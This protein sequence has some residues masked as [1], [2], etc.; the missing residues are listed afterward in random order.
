HAAPAIRAELAGE[1]LALAYPDRIARRRGGAHGQYQLA[2]GRSARLAE[3]DPLALEEWLVA[4]ELG[5]RSGEGSERIYLAAALSPLAFTGA[6]A[7]LVHTEEIAEWSEAEGRFIAER[8]RRV[9]SIV[10]S[11]ERISGV[12][13]GTRSE[14]LCRWIAATG[15]QVLPWTEELRQWQA[16]V[17]LLRSLGEL[18]GAPPWPAVDDTA[19]LATLGEWLAPALIEVGT[20]AA[21]Q[22][23]ALAAALRALLPWPLPRE[24]DRLAPERITVP[25]GSSV[26]I[27]YTRSPPVLAVKL[28]EMFG[29]SSTPAVAEDRV[30][31]LL[32]LLSPAG[33]P[34][35]LTQDLR[36]FWRGAYA[37]VRKDMRGRYPKHPWP[38]D[39]LS[40]R[41]TRHTK[42]RDAGDVT[43]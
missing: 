11:R 18:P 2:N 21:L 28:Q 43:V 13:P 35:A 1:L 23:I 25:S 14:A 27:D 33:R 24:L 15:L 17:V 9:G 37:D 8:R 12:D 30:P 10:L 16:R 3:D 5:S 20:R 39:P 7:P 36:G 41:P 31:L 38:E 4:P 42:R 34:L 29:C 19:L 6:L 32:E 26:A 22:R 40:A